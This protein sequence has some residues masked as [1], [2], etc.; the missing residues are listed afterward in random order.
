MSESLPPELSARALIVRVARA[1]LA[2]R[3][4][5]CVT[6]VLAAVLVA[7]T[8]SMLV[9]VVEKSRQVEKVEA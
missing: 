5:G 7:Y 3:W 2:P 8:T 9:Q 1:Y 4:K 6:A